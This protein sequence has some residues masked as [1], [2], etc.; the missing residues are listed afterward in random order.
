MKQAHIWRNYYPK[1]AVDFFLAHHSEDN[2]MKDIERNRVF[3]CLDGSRNAV[4]TVT[5]KKNEI[6]RLFVLPS[7]QG[8]GYGTEMLDFAEQAIFTQ[9]SKIVL[10]ASLPAKKIYQGRGYMD[11]EF[12]RIAVGNQEFLCYDVMEKRLQMEKGRIVIITGSPGT[13]KTTAASVI[14]K[15]SSL[16]RSV[17]IHNDDFY[18]YLSKGAIPPYLPESNEQN[19]VVMEA[20]FSAAES[21]AHNGYDVI[22]DGI[23]GPWLIGPWQK[24]VEDGYEVHYIILRAEKEETLKRAVGRSKL[25]T[26]TNIELVE[27]MWKQFCNLGNY[28]TKVLTTTELS[29]E[30]TAERIKEGLEKKKYLLR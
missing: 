21:F 14:A 19:K 9:Y 24:A 7:Y 3:L 5:I 28:E 15:E 2:I 26:D 8:M 27:I 18:H 22:V 17:H 23:I 29:L 4:G 12:N 20:V 6:S 10:D 16:S 1:G 25:D 30:E 11:V 13:G